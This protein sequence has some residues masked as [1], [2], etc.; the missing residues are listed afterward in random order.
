MERGGETQ[1][2]PRYGI[3]DKLRKNKVMGGGLDYYPN[4]GAGTVRFVDR[5]GGGVRHRPE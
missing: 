2:S 3:S 1:D 5:V 4:M